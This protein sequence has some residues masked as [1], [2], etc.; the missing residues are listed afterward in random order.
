MNTTRITNKNLSKGHLAFKRD[1]KPA[2]DLS[3]DSHNDLSPIRL[4]S[5]AALMIGLIVIAG[6]WMWIIEIITD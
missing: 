1:F 3:K 6:A 5:A 4:I 2:D